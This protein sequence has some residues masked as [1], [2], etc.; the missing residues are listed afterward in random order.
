[1]ATAPQSSKTSISQ[2]IGTVLV[3]LVPLAIGLGAGYIHLQVRQQIRDQETV[4]QFGV[5]IEAEVTGAT[6]RTIA[7]AGGAN[8][9][10]GSPRKVCQASFRYSPPGGKAVISRQ[11]LAAPMSVCQRY[12]PGDKT[13]A[14]VVPADTRIFLLEGDRINPWWSWASLFGFLIF[15]GLAIIALR[16]VLR[17]RAD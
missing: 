11:L 4:A 9:K 7:P 12:K 8:A 14:W 2:L 3:V 6:V 13:K 17:T 15:C 16:N 5:A 10:T 1:M